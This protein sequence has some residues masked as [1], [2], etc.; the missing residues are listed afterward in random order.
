MT[1]L[2]SK[3]VP[4]LLLVAILALLAVTVHQVVYVGLTQTINAHSSWDELKQKSEAHNV[5]VSAYRECRN[6]LFSNRTECFVSTREVAELRKIERA[7][8]DKV[9]TEIIDLSDYIAKRQ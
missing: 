2:K 7:V 8:S 1:F 6:S 9:M 5:M 4:G 3:V